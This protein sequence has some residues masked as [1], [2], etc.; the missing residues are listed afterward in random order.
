MYRL[1]LQR[2]QAMTKLR[3][4]YSV[5]LYKRT[6][7]ENHI[8]LA[9]PKRGAKLKLAPYEQ[10][11]RQLVTDHPDAMLAELHAMLPNKD[12][13]TV[14]TLHNFLVRLKITWKKDSPCSGAASGGCFRPAGR[15][16]EVAENF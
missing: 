4:K 10:E 8:K 16:A 11:V 14:V 5:S 3:W 15:V 6:S 12:E 13:V 1:L 9:M 2:G 7:I